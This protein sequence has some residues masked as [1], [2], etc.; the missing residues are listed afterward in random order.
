MA[1]AVPSLAHAEG[2]DWLLGVKPVFEDTSP[3]L[4]V[5]RFGV[6]LAANG[7]FGPS[8]LFPY[9]DAGPVG[10]SLAP[11]LAYR[12]GANL[13]LEAGLDVTYRTLRE[14]GLVA[15]DAA[16][17]EMGG[18]GLSLGLRYDYDP[19]TR[20]GVS[21]RSELRSDP[22]AGRYSVARGSLLEPAL[23]T[24][25]PQIL[26]ASVQRQLGERWSLLGSVGI[27]QAEPLALR[28]DAWTAGVGAQYRLHEDL[29]VGM[30]LEYSTG[31]GADAARR[32]VARDLPASDGGSY[33]F[34]LDL[35]WRF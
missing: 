20:L 22:L 29:G 11:A 27:Q 25:A 15:P 23:R 31:N 35:N 18:V 10:F 3:A 19:R 2:I 9:P 21:Y 14:P 26:S 6:G 34:G 33:F 17:P 8:G 13:A 7:H 5:G 32:N 24:G 28:A 16:S 30:A 12:A 1:L 4:G